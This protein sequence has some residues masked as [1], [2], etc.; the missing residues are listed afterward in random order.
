MGTFMAS[1]A[2]RRSENWEAVKPEIEQL[3]QGVTGLVTNLDQDRSAYAIVSPYGDEGPILSELVGPISRLTGGYAVMA[4]C[5]DSD[6]N[7]LDLYRDGELVERC[8]IGVCFEEFAEV[9]DF[10]E[11]NLENWK[12]LLLDPAQEAALQDAFFEE[13]VFAEENLR[14]LS[15][16]TGLPIFDDAM[17]FGE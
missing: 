17:V 8:G 4:I 3:Y 16:L 6:L 11:P 12:P 14:K 13:A 9:D 15:A 1:V 2:F 10:S 7:I 5:V